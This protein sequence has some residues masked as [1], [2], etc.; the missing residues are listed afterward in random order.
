MSENIFS[1]LERKSFEDLD[2]FFLLCQ[3]DYAQLEHEWSNSDRYIGEIRN[4]SHRDIKEVEADLMDILRSGDISSLKP[5]EAYYQHDVMEHFLVGDEWA[6]AQYYIEQIEEN[7]EMISR[8][9]NVSEYDGYG[10]MIKDGWGHDDI[11]SYIAQQTLEKLKSDP[12]EI[13]SLDIGLEQSYAVE[14]GGELVFVRNSLFSGEYSFNRLESNYKYEINEIK[15]WVNEPYLYDYINNQYFKPNH[16]REFYNDLYVKEELYGQFKESLEQEK[17]FKEADLEKK[18]LESV[19]DPVKQEEK[20]VDGKWTYQT[21]LDHAKQVNPDVSNS[22]VAELSQKYLTDYNFT[23]QGVANLVVDEVSKRV[24]LLGKG[25][26]AVNIHNAICKFLHAEQTDYNINYEKFV[27]NDVQEH[28]PA[29]LTESLAKNKLYKEAVEKEK[30]EKQSS[31][32]TS[33][34]RKIKI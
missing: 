26:D 33:A 3:C 11:E 21:L 29:Y 32:T 19:I 5:M 17:N 18:H 12:N 13:Y 2:L 30:L 23:S 31:T 22:L 6:V 9:V 4:Y 7:P 27:K 25:E 24:S 34:S 15:Q 1:N 10:E 8:Y 14:V 20:T 16:H 28:E